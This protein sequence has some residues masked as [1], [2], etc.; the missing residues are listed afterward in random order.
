MNV[1]RKG[2]SIY[3]IITNLARWPCECETYRGASVKSTDIRYF[4]REGFGTGSAWRRTIKPAESATFTNTTFHTVLNS[5]SPINIFRN[6]LSFQTT[7]ATFTEYCWRFT[8][9]SKDCESRSRNESDNSGDSYD[10]SIVVSEFLEVHD[11][12]TPL[13]GSTKL[14]STSPSSHKAKAVIFY[15]A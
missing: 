11:N 5:P 15:R 1:V 2:I 7:V 12:T 9:N 10:G 3:T 14:T 13:N 8:A 4:S 6:E